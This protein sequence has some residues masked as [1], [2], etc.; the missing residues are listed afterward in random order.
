MLFV[1]TGYANATAGEQ[2]LQEIIAKQEILEINSL[3]SHSWDSKNSEKLSEIF[4]EDAFYK[5]EFIKTQNGWKI[6]RRAVF[7]D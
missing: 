5:D 1:I 6:R 2:S 7:G 4:T 3:Y